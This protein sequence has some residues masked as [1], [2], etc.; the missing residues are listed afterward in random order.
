[1]PDRPNKYKKKDIT[2]KSWR[3]Q[4]KSTRTK[5]AKEDLKKDRS[6]KAKRPGYRKSSTGSTYYEARKNRSDAKG[7]RI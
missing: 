6:L 2:K 1:M 7:K 5:G 4:T 3:K